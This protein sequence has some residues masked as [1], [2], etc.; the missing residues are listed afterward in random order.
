MN[1]IKPFIFPVCVATIWVV[2]LAR[3]AQMVLA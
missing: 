2:N 3:I 1:Y